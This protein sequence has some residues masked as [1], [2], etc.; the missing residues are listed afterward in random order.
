M[1]FGSRN[2][3]TDHVGFFDEKTQA[4]FGVKGQPR[5]MLS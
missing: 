3:D 4:I 1:Y 5:S 2:Q